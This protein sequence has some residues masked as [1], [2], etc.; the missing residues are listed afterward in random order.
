MNDIFL[1]LLPL[2]LICIWAFWSKYPVAYQL[3]SG[4]SLITGFEWF[5][6][7]GTD[8]ALVFSFVLIVFSILMAFTAIYLMF[9]PK[10]EGVQ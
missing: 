4:I 7:F 10:K 5:D 8:S 2:V 3:L 1:M 9:T 6:T